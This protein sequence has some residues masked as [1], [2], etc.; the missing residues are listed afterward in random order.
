VNISDFKSQVDRQ[1]VARTNKWE[2]KIYPPSQMS[3]S[4]ILM[5]DILFKGGN[6]VAADFG[7]DAIDPNNNQA[8]VY[9]S[10]I[11]GQPVT[12]KIISDQGSLNALSIYAISC[13]IPS[14]DILNMEFEEYGEPRSLGIKH[15]HTDFTTRFICSE[16]LRE[17]DFFESWQDVI[18]DPKTKKHGYYND[19]IGHVEVVKY[20]AGGTQEMARYKF[21]EAYPTNIGASEL[22]AEGNLLELDITWK[23]RNYERIK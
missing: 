3:K 14:R 5:K 23:F 1:G 10:R 2:L 21:S 17:R 6:F 18:F 7:N 13:S 9:G 19:Y 16:D 15:V 20:S 11:V 12:D 8:A 22:T 4:G